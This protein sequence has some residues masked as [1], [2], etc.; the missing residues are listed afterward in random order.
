[1]KYTQSCQCDRFERCAIVSFLY[2]LLF[3]LSFYLKQYNEKK[4]YLVQ[5][6]NFQYS[7]LTA[8]ESID[9]YK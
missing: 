3:S 4:F 8:P 2:N 5:I 1:M 6:R 9:N 7:T